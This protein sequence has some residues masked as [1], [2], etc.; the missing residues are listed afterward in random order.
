MAKATGRRLC[1]GAGW[2]RAGLY[3]RSYRHAGGGGRRPSD[4]GGV[5]VGIPVWPGLGRAGLS[6][7]AGWPMSGQMPSNLLRLW[8]IGTAL[9]GTAVLVWAF[10]PVLVFIGLLTL[11]LGVLALTM[12]GLARALERALGKRR[13]DRSD[14]GPP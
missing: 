5:R 7:L 11:G 3:C 12:I 9:I 4:G 10:A 6:V 1:R 2:L 13:H 14:G 8:L